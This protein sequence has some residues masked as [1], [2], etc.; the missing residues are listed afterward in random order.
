MYSHCAIIIEVPDLRS[1][2]EMFP[3]MG[4]DE[5]MGDDAEEEEEEEVSDDEISEMCS[6]ERKLDPIEWGS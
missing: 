5:E 2:A 4:D 1:R 3:E 6:R